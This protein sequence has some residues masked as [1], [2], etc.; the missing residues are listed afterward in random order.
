MSN[1]RVFKLSSGNVTVTATG[2]FELE[3]RISSSK[4]QKFV[5][6]NILS[7][8][9]FGQDSSKR[10]YFYTENGQAINSLYIHKIKTYFDPD[11]NNMD[12]KNVLT[13][14]N[15]RDVRIASMSDAEHSQLVKLKLKKSNPN[16]VLTNIDFVVDQKHNLTKL[17]VKAMHIIFTSE[18]TSKQLCFICAHFNIPYSLEESMEESK[19]D[20]LER[21]LK[22]WL[23]RDD[24]NSRL[25][26]EKIDSITEMEDAFYFDQFLSYGFIVFENSFYR[27]NN[28]T[29]PIGL[30][31]ESV[32]AY[33]R[34]HKENYDYL[35][36][37]VAKV[38]KEEKKNFK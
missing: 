38:L 37:E 23:D 11:K 15:H 32:I 19:R 21:K 7:E 3:K 20:A 12:L 8:V 31:R 25:L 29:V 5:L 6:T 18:Y 16:Y 26:I 1:N 36:M 2:K 35:K 17:K 13:L 22:S 4:L 30:N 27:M 33:F 10:Q 9:P 28:D 14:I 24:D 34:T